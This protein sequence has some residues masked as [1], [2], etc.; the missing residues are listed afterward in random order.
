MSHKLGSIAR[1]SEADFRELVD[2]WVENYHGLK[3]TS[4]YE[5]RIELQRNMRFLKARIDAAVWCLTHKRVDRFRYA[6][7]YFRKDEQHRKDFV[8]SVLFG[9]RAHLPW[10][11]REGL[12]VSPIVSFAAAMSTNH[13]D[14]F[15]SPPE[16]R[17]R[18]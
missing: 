12:A 6:C 8:E 10:V 1:M 15:D 9:W 3:Q 11:R 16:L 5:K 18:A 7:M 13:L 4:K 2:R 17:N 14:A